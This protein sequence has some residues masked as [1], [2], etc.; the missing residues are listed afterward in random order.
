MK[1][2]TLTPTDPSDPNR[3]S[4]DTKPHSR[5]TYDPDE[6]ENKMM[7]ES[8]RRMNAEREAKEKPEIYDYDEVE[9][10]SLRELF[11]CWK[12][13]REAKEKK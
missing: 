1:R 10:K 8:L 7:I 11:D 6:V 5:E 2:P 9:N 4:T 3:S 12:A 13:E